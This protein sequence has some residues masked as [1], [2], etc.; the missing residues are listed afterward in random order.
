MIGLSFL[1]NSDI[2]IDLS[3]H[4][5]TDKIDNLTKWQFPDSGAVLEPSQFMLVWCD[6]GSGTRSIA[7]EFQTIIWW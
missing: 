6:E 1:I 4:F 2:A 3:S 5:L 7:Y